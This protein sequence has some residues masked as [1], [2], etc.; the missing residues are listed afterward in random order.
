MDIHTLN[1][2]PHYRLKSVYVKCDLAND[3]PHFSPK[4]ILPPLKH[5]PSYGLALDVVTL[6]S[7]KAKKVSIVGQKSPLYK[8]YYIYDDDFGSFVGGF[9]VGGAFWQR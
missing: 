5:R 9:N 3:V 6:K 7:S 2:I 8:T 1:S 4:K